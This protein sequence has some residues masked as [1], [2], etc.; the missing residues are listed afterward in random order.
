ME[1]KV[2]LSSL[3]DEGFIKDGKNLNVILGRDS[4]GKVVTADIVEL[5][6]CFLFGDVASGKTMCLNTILAS[7]LLKNTPSDLRLILCDP[8]ECE[9]ELYKDIPHLAGPIVHTVDEFKTMIEWLEGE[10]FRRYRQ[11]QD[12]G[13]DNIID[14]NKKADV[15][16]LPYIIL[17][18]DEVCDYRSYKKLE[19]YIQMINGK[20]RRAGIY[21]I[22]AT[23]R[24][25]GLK[26]VTKNNFGFYL[27]FKMTSVRKAMVVIGDFGKTKLNGNGDMLLCDRFRGKRLQGAY[28]SDEDISSIVSFVNG[29]N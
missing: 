9:F 24:T 26:M 20:G 3:Y 12:N 18:I 6:H 8:K 23:Q 22:A 27:M 21:L 15:E 4:D 10:L 13:V 7:L 16:K 5:R 14:Y 11:L 19:S 29:C 2:L 25:D 1:N 28:I 17:M